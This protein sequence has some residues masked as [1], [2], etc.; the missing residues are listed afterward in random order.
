MGYLILSL[1]P[2]AGRVLKVA[3]SPSHRRL[4][5]GRKLLDEGIECMAKARVPCVLLH[6]DPQREAAVELYRSSGFEVS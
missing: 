4:G 5:I 3:V 2:D 1:S 6:V